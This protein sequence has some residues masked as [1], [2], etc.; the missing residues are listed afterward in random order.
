MGA[1]H[2]SAARE[3]IDPDLG[4]RLPPATEAK[5]PRSFAALLGSRP[6]EPAVL[7]ARSMNQAWMTTDASGVATWKL[8]LSSR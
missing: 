4:Q 3:V 6:A 5:V 8:K 1:Q 2:V 7:R